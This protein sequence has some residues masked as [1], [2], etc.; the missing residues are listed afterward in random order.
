M[1]AEMQIEPAERQYVVKKT[2]PAY[3]MLKS[4]AVGFDSV[5]PG[6]RVNCPKPFLNTLAV[7]M[8]ISGRAALHYGDHQARHIPGTL[9]LML[10]ELKFYEIAEYNWRSCWFVL[11]GPL[12]EAFVAD[13]D[14]NSLALAIENTPGQIRFNMFEACRSILEQTGNWQWRWLKY[15]TTVLDYIQRRCVNRDEQDSSL[16]KRACDLMTENLTSPLPLPKIAEILNVS[17]SAFSHQFRKETGVSPGLTYRRMR[18]DKAKQFLVNGLSV[19][20]TSDQTGFENPFHFSRL[21]KKTEGISPSEFKK[22]TS[23]FTLKRF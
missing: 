16:G 3:G 21:F 8:T 4:M 11:W 1:K 10:P 14:K 7:E 12:A 13:I 19:S 17:L 23:Q 18:I 20:E 22:Q 2:D 5:R 9:M 15:L 6:T